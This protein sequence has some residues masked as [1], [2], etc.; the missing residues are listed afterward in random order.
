M[1]TEEL[2]E[3]SSGK[4]RGAQPSGAK[5]VAC[6]F[7]R[8]RLADEYYFTCRKCDASY[9][10][11]HTSRHQPALCARQVGK[12]RRQALA[13]PPQQPQQQDGGVHPGGGHQLLLAGHDS[14]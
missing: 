10:Y 5:V 12:R 3:V 14:C 11:I 6:A 4:D 7:C 1:T 8:R 13:A 9:C 2:A